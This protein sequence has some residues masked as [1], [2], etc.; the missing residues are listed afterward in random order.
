MVRS[1]NHPL[2]VWRAFTKDFTQ[3]VDLKNLPSFF[4]LP[5]YNQ[6]SSCFDPLSLKFDLVIPQHVC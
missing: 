5:K 1:H 3:L 2:Q 6:H 4:Q